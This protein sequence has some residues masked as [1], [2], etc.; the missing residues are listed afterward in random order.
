[1]SAAKIRLR[2]QSLGAQSGNGQI[3]ALHLNRRRVK[4][5]ESKAK[6]RERSA[7]WRLR[8]YWNGSKVKNPKRL[9][10]FVNQQAKQALPDSRIEEAWEK[11]PV[12]TIQQASVILT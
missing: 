10:A 3:H 1:M 11:T 12:T 8:R 7:R 5:E 9:V 4:L 2:L 6:L